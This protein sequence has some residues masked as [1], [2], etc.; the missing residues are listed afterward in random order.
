MINPH[1]VVYSMLVVVSISRHTHT[2]AAV[3]ILFCRSESH[4]KPSKLLPALFLP[5]F[6]ALALNGGKKCRPVK[7]P[8]SGGGEQIRVLDAFRILESDSYLKQIGEADPRPD[9]PPPWKRAPQHDL[10]LGSWELWP[11]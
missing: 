2:E 7:P 1:N 9:A 11:L 5:L 6:A 4:K 8:L 3:S 10:F